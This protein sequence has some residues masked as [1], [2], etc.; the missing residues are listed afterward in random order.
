MEA[1]VIDSML[2]SSQQGYSAY[3]HLHPSV[4]TSSLLTPHFVIL[5]FGLGTKQSDVFDKIAI[6]N[7]FVIDAIL[8]ASINS[9][10]NLP[11]RARPFLP[12]IYDSALTQTATSNLNMVTNHPD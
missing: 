9:P 12:P 11:K 1:T 6:K 2:N 5:H 10:L 3:T 8:L 7:V 4:W